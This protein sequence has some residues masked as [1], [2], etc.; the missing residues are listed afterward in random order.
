MAKHILTIEEQAVIA[1]QRAAAY[2]DFSPDGGLPEHWH[3]IDRQGMGGRRGSLIDLRTMG[4]SARLHHRIH[5]EGDSVLDDLPA[6][7]AFSDLFL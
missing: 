1:Q 7:P 3:H 6:R 4:V 2:A 5:T